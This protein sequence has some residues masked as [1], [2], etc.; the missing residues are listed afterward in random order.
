[1]NEHSFRVYNVILVCQLR[2]ERKA[3]IV[4]WALSNSTHISY[5]LQDSM[6]IEF[7]QFRATLC[8][9]YS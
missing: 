5:T 8:L 3:K 7:T 2:K 9:T 1:M 4:I 6:C